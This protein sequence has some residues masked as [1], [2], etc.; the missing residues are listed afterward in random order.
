MN[1][2]AIAFILL[3]SLIMMTA[4][5]LQNSFNPPPAADDPAL[6]ANQDVA[7]DLEDRDQPV[8]ADE[9]PGE[10]VQKPESAKT[11]AADPAPS[12][13]ATDVAAEN[14][15]VAL[16]DA[17]DVTPSHCEDQFVSLG[18]LGTASDDRYLMAVNLCGGTIHR[19]ELNYRPKQDGRI[20][21]RD[22]EYKG[23]YLGSL[24]CLDTDQ[25]CLVRTVGD[26]TPAADAVANG[27]EGGIKPGDILVALN[28]EPIVSAEEFNNRLAEKTKP[29]QTVQLKVKREGTE[30]V[31]DVELTDKP[32]EL[33]RPEKSRIDPGYD[34]PESFVF[35]LIKPM[36]VVDAAWPDIDRNMRDGLWKLL[37]ADPAHPGRISMS[38]EI[39]ED[40]LQAAGF[41]GPLTV[42]KHFQLPEI[43][44]EDFYDLGSRTFHYNL[45]IEIA[46]GSDQP[47]TVAFE[48]DGPTGSPSE[49]WWYANKIHGRSTAIGYTAGARDIVGSNEK[50]PFVFYGCPEIAKGASED[51]PD[52]YY[53]CSPLVDSPKA[54]MLNSVGVDAQYFNTSLIPKTGD[55][56]PFVCNAVTAF[57]NGGEIPDNVRLQ[58]LMDVTFQLVK[59]VDI[60]PE[61]SYKQTFEIFSGPK[62]AEL[63]QN[64]GL[65]NVRTFGW[66]AAFSKP[67]MSLLHF[68]YWITGSFSYGLAIVMLTVLVRL[69]MVPFSRKAALNAQMMQHLQP[70]MKEI[71]DKYK[72][73]M[74]KRAA[75]QREL[76]KRHK[77]NPFGGCFM[78]FFQLP[79]FIGLYR[80]LAVDNSLRDQPLFPGLGWCS[81]LSG[82]D[83]FLYWKDWMPSMLADETG[84][85]GP[86][87][88][89]LPLITMVLFIAQ[90]KLFMPPAVDDQ[91][92]MMQKMMTFMMV[93]MGIL[94][95]KV[96]A[97]LC[98]YFITSSIWGIIERKLLPKPVLDTDSL[99]GE[100][101]PDTQQASA[102]S[103]AEEKA[104]L[105]QEE[106][107][108]LRKRRN[109][110]RKKRLRERGV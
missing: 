24:D 45:D 67:L 97:G 98:V 14:Q 12:D 79:I 84:W 1:G 7:N 22:L 36:K 90:Q 92:K 102:P 54:R 4:M 13:I 61:S 106:E 9:A 53:V 76:F 51:P 26:G 43:P 110:E 19:V 23:G 69:I 58:K 82:P 33:L 20:K 32:I 100:V 99:P 78:M 48:L 40:K 109:A 87:L 93:F 15:E 18:S 74:E 55:D 108:L 80:G 101:A 96:P 44:P 72:D 41:A 73:D 64:Y 91:Q 56:Q 77:Y 57:T 89:I 8:V 47:L 46:N 85:L 94:F 52:V 62:E 49:T 104:A 68:F 28:D 29:R 31:F 83:Q 63:L 107:R 59:T 6:V 86:Y 25:G 30:L 21:Y 3:S 88:N 39:P 65:D 11:E 10:I 2:R 35:S 50:Q 5:I 16:E 71:A 27:V 17:A 38:Y 60:E 66:F 70:Q 37:P 34:Y 105:K 95:F 103:K 42:Y 75:A 81:N